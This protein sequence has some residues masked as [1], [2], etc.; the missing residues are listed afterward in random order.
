MN[1]LRTLLIAGLLS[2]VLGATPES[3]TSGPVAPTKPSQLVTLR[4]SSGNDC[5]FNGQAVDRQI[6]PD[7]TLQPF[8]IPPKQV[9]VV[10]EINWG[11]VFGPASQSAIVAVSVQGP[12]AM[13]SNAFFVDV[14]PTDS[15]GAAGRTSQVANAIVRSGHTLCVDSVTDGTMTMNVRGFLTKDR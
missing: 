11:V 5:P 10:T 15:A 8:T 7:G 2:A 13:P 1:T 9:L 3:A 6:L 4:N 12:S 14:V